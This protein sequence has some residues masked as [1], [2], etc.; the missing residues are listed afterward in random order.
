M[1]NVTDALI[2][3]GQVLI[4][5]VALTVC[6]SS[7][8][9]LRVSI[10]KAIDQTEII[11]F[12]KDGDLYYNFIES[13]SNGA[14]RTVGAETVVSSMYRAIKEDYTLYLLF[15]KDSTY[16]SAFSKLKDDNIIFIKD[17]IDFKVGDTTK[18]LKGLKIT[19]SS[20]ANYTTDKM[21]RNGLYDVIKDSTFEEYLGE[22]QEK[23]S[24]AVSSENKLTKRIITYVEK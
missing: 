13:Q 22:Y 24:D 7:F 15:T 4:F 9:T 1:E 2:M 21:L 11:E 14:T 6:M 10:D 20:D 16:T 5:I 23:T 18:K 19:I 8:S 3:A 12:A 17:G